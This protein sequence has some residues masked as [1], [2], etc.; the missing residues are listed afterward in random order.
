MKDKETE[1]QRHRDKYA[2]NRDNH[3]AQK[4]EY[5]KTYSER[6]AILTIMRKYN[7]TETT[8]KQF[9][10]DSMGSCNCCGE[11]WNPLLHSRR[12]SID[13][14]HDTGKVRGILC[15]N[16]NSSLGLLNESIDKMNKLIAYTKNVCNK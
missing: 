9:Y 5:E 3:L 10:L 12:F 6:R 4:K 16:C 15:Q 14:D 2:K 11:H 8:A 7:L 13:H 1:R